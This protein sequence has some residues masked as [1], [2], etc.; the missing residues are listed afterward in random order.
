MDQDRNAVCPACGAHIA[1]PYAS[2]LQVLGTRIEC[3]KCHFWWTLHR[4][5]ELSSSEDRLCVFPEDDGVPHVTLS[6]DS[7]AFP[8]VV[9]DEDSQDIFRS[10]KS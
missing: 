8:V 5:P 4:V 9:S 3:R 10:R 7:E 1:L 2:T 6:P